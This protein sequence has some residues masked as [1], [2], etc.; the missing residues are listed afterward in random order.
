MPPPPTSPVAS[1][2][3]F[4]EDESFA[5][6]MDR[7]DPLA[8]C[9]DLFHIPRATDIAG[10]GGGPRVSGDGPCVYLCGNSL[11]CMPKAARDAVE[12]E[13][14]DWQTYGVEAHLHGAHPWLPYHEELRETGASLV[15]ARG[16]EVVHMN[17]LT[18][19]LHLMMASF[20]RPTSQR[21][22]IVIED[23]AFPSD[24]YAAMTQAA[25][26]GY[27]PERAVVRLK[28]RAGEKC[29][30]DVDVQA[31]F[32]E[33]GK[34][35][36]LVLLGGVNY[37]TG[38]W[39]DMERITAAAKAAGCVVG[40]DLAHA[41]GNV[42][43][44]LHDWGVDFAAWCT[45]K[46]LNSGPGAVAGCFVHEDN[47]RNTRWFG[48]GA[49]P[50]F[51]GWW[52]NDP[53]TR[54]KM[55]PAFEPVPTAEA[56]QLSN[57]PILSM[58]PVRVSLEI[59]QR[60]G[61]AALREK[62]EKLTAYL[63]W[64]LAREGEAGVFEVITPR[65]PARRGSALSISVAGG[66]KELLGKLRAEGVVCDFREPNVIRAAPVPLYNSFRDVWRFA[67]ILKGLA[68]R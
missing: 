9:R 54:F 44:R 12:Q 60:V 3:A 49:L 43:V 13:L 55:G 2:A 18:V 53:A 10:V 38:Q 35:V 6:E 63:E 45:Y 34:S 5:V 37:L 42:P 4:R 67:G 41:A 59:F 40:W 7:A 68:G 11:G 24:G 28:P 19:N 58:A 23:A 65:D 25:F 14:R 31:F 57:P 30:R 52:G 66:G 51:G 62:A 20:Y 50:R 15:G 47:A 16:G 61:M 32:D 56:W 22:R 33:E 46:F 1:S 26:H 8:S 39:M 21:H 36:A 29:L 64:L 17:S 48:D 27:D